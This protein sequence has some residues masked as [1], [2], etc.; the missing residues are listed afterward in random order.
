[1]LQPKKYRFFLLEK[2]N[3]QLDELASDLMNAR[4][5]SGNDELEGTRTDNVDNL[6]E[7]PKEILGLQKR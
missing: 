1:M 2:E 3:D 5:T 4:C 6:E 7:I